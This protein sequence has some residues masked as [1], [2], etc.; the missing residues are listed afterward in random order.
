MIQSNKR[1]YFYAEPEHD[2]SITRDTQTNTNFQLTKCCSSC[3]FS[4]DIFL[5]IKLTMGG[6]K[7]TRELTVLEKQSLHGQKNPFVLG[8]SLS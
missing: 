1:K 2:V 4:I 6:G 5:Y 7:V 8:L 3:S